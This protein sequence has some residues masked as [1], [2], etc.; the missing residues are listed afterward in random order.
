MKLGLI[1]FRQFVHM[2]LSSVTA[3]VCLMSMTEALAQTNGAA[4]GAGAGPTLE[5]VVVTAERQAEALSR[6]PISVAALTQP[7]LEQR[8][9][10]TFDDIAPLIPGLT[11]DTTSDVTG[12]SR[13]FIDI[14]GIFSDVGAA[15][16]GVYIDDTPIQVRNSGLTS[17]NVYPE[18][19]DLDRVEV[20][21][22]PQGT[23]FGAGSEGGTVRF[24][25]VQPSLTT[26]SLTA[27]SELSFTQSGDSSYEAG[28]AGGGPVAEDVGF[29]GSLYYRHTGGWID[30]IDPNTGIVLD[31]NA[32][33]GDSYAGRVAFR[34]EPSERLVLGASVFA[35]KLESGSSDVY[36]VKL[37]DPASSQFKTG[38]V[39]NTPGQ[40]RFVLP[41]VSAQYNFDGST[42]YF[43][44]SY[45]SRRVHIEPD[46]TQYVLDLVLGSPYAPSPADYS[47]GLFDDTQ[48]AWTAEARWQYGNADSRFR[49]VVGAF[50]QDTKQFS[51]EQVQTPN[52]P[53]YFLN[54]YGVDYITVFGAPLAANDSISTENISTDDKQ[55]AGYLQADYQIIDRLRLTAGVRVSSVKFNFV[56]TQAGPFGSGG[57]TSGSQQNTPVTP[58]VGLSYEIKNGYMVYASAAKGFRPGGAQEKP[59]IC[60]PDLPAYGLTSVPKTYDPDSDWSYEVGS[61]NKLAS[62]RVELDGSLFL[63]NWNQRQTSIYMPT[64]GQFFIT[65]A[66]GVARSKGFDLSAQAQLTDRLWVYGAAGYTDA[67]F[68]DAFVLGSSVIADEGSPLALNQRPWHA[69]VSSEYRF[70]AFGHRGYGRIDYQYA[71]AGPTPD[72]KLAGYDPEIPRLDKTDNVNARLGL[73]L[74][75]FDVS[76]FVKNA[77]N[78]HGY[79]QYSHD[80]IGAPLFYGISPQP[81]NIGLTVNY[82]Y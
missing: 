56:D 17:T 20:L 66:T 79:T 32:N 22:G 44:S 2:G 37:S 51:G 78:F 35:Q 71:S 31:P 8:G 12:P 16:T 30:R 47:R 70:P 54:A 34:Y 55:L 57:G 62:N 74:E 9:V 18:I 75:R 69:S 59:S 53:T 36:W 50:Y 29:R 82:N 28:V 58:K 33:T 48:D 64:C 19:F 73:A 40:D 11:F 23:L 1:R 25:N 15:T 26:S 52:F 72:P 21:R 63:I 65:N 10:K 60:N 14:R 27:R 80:N 6:V 3:V 46:F 76:L 39:L 24:I 7:E 13:S 42:L 5:E 43:T 67:Y 45:L 38:N 49:L 81:R 77:F 61:K 68:K 41:A 4:A